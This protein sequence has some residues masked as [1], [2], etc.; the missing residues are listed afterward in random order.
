MFVLVL[1]IPGCVIRCKQ[2]AR[3]DAV[4][5][6][7]WFWLFGPTVLHSHPLPGN[8]VACCGKR[9]L[10]FL[11]PELSNVSANVSACALTLPLVGRG[12][13]LAVPY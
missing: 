3:V 10:L 7:A 12:L 11:G 5:R 4:G 13:T 1:G 9:P 6:T 8:D 2:K